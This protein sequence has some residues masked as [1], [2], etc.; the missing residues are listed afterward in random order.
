MSL[1][2]CSSLF[3]TNDCQFGDKP[4]HSTK[5]A[6]LLLHETIQHYFNFDNKSVFACFLDASKAFDS[7]DHTKLFS[8]LLVRGVSPIF[9]RLY[10]TMYASFTTFIL[11][12]NASSISIHICL[13]VL[14]GG[15]S[16]PIFFLCYIDIF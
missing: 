15:V 7:V 6:G 3:E 9:I 4:R 5:H 14:Q 11:W 13:G 10:R 12:D 2:L 8:N 1:F 16:S